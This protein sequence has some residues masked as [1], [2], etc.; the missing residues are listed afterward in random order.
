MKNVISCDVESCLL[1]RG[2]LPEWHSAVEAHRQNIIFKKGAVIFEEGRSATGIYFLYRGHVKVHKQWVN[3]KQLILRFA[4]EGDMIGFRGLGT[5][6]TYPVSA[7]ALNDVTVC[8]VSLSFFEA[9]LR[10]NHQLTYTLMEFYANELLAAERRMRD[11]A[12]MDVKGRIA[13]MLLMLKDTFGT[14]ANGAIGI[15]LSRQDMASYV[16]TAYE[17]FFRVLSDMAHEK[18]VRLEGKAIIIADQPALQGIVSQ[19]R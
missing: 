5:D 3:D 17:T 8:F 13:A 14:Q 7:T 15:S 1:C 19:R 4:R 12:H 16:G 9:T 18:I 10:V 11:L 2:C 6:R